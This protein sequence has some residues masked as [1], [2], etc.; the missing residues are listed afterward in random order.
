METNIIRFVFI[1]NTI[2]LTGWGLLTNYM[3]SH[4]PVSITYIY[5]YGKFNANVRHT[6]AK[7]GDIPK[8][9]FKHFYIFAASVSTVILCLISYKHLYDGKIPEIIFTLLDT[10]FGASRKPLVPVENLILASILLCVHCWKRL[11]E[12]TCVNIFSDQHISII[13][14]V[15]GFIHYAGTCLC[16]IGESEGF[17]RG[18]QTNRSWNKLTTTTIACAFIFLLSTYMQL[19]SNF[20]LARLRK[21]KDGVVVSHDYKIPFYGLFE[22]VSGPLQFTEILIYVMLSLILWQ[23]STFHYVTVWVIAN[24]IECAYLTHW[25]FRKNFKN[26]PKKRKMLIPYVW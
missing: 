13:H 9:W 8:R 25:W 24:Q 23:A 26:Y 4:L 10:L 21:N 16:L 2:A 11:Y 6:L 14:Y 12:T 7:K 17:V 5:R 20:I 18:P 1:I 3:E 15:L 19:H 22:Y